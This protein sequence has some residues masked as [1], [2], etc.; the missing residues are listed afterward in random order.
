MDSYKKFELNNDECEYKYDY[1]FG[2]NNLYN[3]S[4]QEEY[5][6]KFDT[7][8]NGMLSNNISNIKKRRT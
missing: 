6:K 5:E 3:A 8:L 4:I 2:V 1:N 7:L